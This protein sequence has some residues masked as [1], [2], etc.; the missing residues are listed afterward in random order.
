MDLW[1]P[2]RLH[3]WIPCPFQGEILTKVG[4][5]T[6]QNK[7]MHRKNVEENLTLEKKQVV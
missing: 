7:K 4:A 6:E 3:Y 1:Y 5:F 2:A